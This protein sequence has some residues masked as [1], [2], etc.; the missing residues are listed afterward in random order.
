[1]MEIAIEAN[2]DGHVFSILAKCSHKVQHTVYGS[3]PLN[4]VMEPFR[5]KGADDTHDDEEAD[6]G[7]DCVL[8]SS[9][10]TIHQ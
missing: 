9:S 10:D 5:G 7:C 3:K 6:R 1:M 2:T 8:C 4:G